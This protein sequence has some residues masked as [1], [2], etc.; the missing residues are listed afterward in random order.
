MRWEIYPSLL[1]MIS[2]I[3]KLVLKLSNS[4]KQFSTITSSLQPNFTKVLINFSSYFKR[5]FKTFVAI[6]KPH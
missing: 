6:L 4:S 5:K 3:R 2:F 1:T